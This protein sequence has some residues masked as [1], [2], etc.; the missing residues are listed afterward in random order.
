MPLYAGL[1]RPF[2]D[3]VVISTQMQRGPFRFFSFLRLG[4]PSKVRISCLTSGEGKAKGRA[5]PEEFLIFPDLLLTPGTTRD[6]RGLLEAIPANRTTLCSLKIVINP[7]GILVH[8][9]L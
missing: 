3:Q 4:A 2:L 6:R 7:E 9:S 5:R 1:D 8:A